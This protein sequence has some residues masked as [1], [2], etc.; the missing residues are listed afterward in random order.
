M[1][2]KRRRVP[3]RIKWRVLI[4]AAILI[5]APATAFAA[6][7]YA[8][9]TVNMRA[10]P[11]TEYPVVMTIP[12]GAHITINGCLSD[13]AWCDVT[14]RRNRGWVSA[15]YLNY[16]YGNR[17]VYLPDYV[18][19]VGVPIVTFS[20]GSY[21]N[22]YYAGRPWFHRRAHWEQVWRSQGR[23]GQLRAGG[24][25]LPA[26]RQLGPA[27]QAIIAQ[28]GRTGRA[29]RLETGRRIGARG[30]FERRNLEARFNRRNAMGLRGG[31]AA[32]SRHGL[33]GPVPNVGRSFGQ[34]GGPQ[35]QARRAQ[36]APQHTAVPRI[37]SFRPHA[38]SN[39]GGRA[40]GGANA[41]VGGPRGGAPH[42]SAPQVS[43]PRGGGAPHFGGGGP[44]MG[45][46]M[47]GGGGPRGAGGGHGHR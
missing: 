14:F 30:A 3:M 4:A 11:G 37:G 39:F 43:A 23:Y 40:F 15:D 32:A 33:R 42:I 17:Y 22:R 25:G 36:P 46:P 10:G 38:G 2:W 20:L 41:S 44:R 34:P 6:R 35:F 7:G 26:V 21:W 24:R 16:F 19:V 28:P 8:T 9:N 12:G 18:G 31:Q 27:Q 47:G 5:V 1:Q 13:Y 29:G 45:A